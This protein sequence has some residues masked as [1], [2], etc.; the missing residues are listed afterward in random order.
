VL[1]EYAG[2]EQHV[3]RESCAVALDILDYWG[4]DAAGA[5]GSTD[6]AAGSGGGAVADESS[7]EAEDETIVKSWRGVKK[8][9][10]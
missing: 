6:I 8:A 5:N 1:R 9:S 10:A 3:V 4:D 2:D 7:S